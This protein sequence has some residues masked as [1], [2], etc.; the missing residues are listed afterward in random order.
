M[1]LIWVLKVCTMG[2]AW[3][4]S[5]TCSDLFESAC[6]AKV[7][8]QIRAGCDA[9]TVNTYGA[10]PLFVAA[11]TGHLGTA[12][13]LVENG[14]NVNF[15]MNGTTPLHVACWTGHLATA[16]LLLES[17]ADANQAMSIPRR[18]PTAVESRF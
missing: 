4:H 15:S 8:A 12:R 13:L 2:V 6:V 16:R 3:A 14:A 1:M 7:A 9:N 18:R 11:E 5:S 10:S 17:G